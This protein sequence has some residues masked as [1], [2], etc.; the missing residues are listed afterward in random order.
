MYV[1]LGRGEEQPLVNSTPSTVGEVE[2]EG[3]VKI[4][5]QKGCFRSPEIVRLDQI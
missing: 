5:N 3:R 1:S 2:V 4:K